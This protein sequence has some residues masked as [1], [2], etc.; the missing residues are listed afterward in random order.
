MDSSKYKISLLSLDSKFATTHDA[1]NGEFKILLPTTIKNVMRIR[2]A[3][4]EIPFIEYEFSGRH[5]NTTF[6]VKVG[7]ATTFTKCDP[8]PDGNYTAAQLVAAVEDS[9]QAVHASFTCTHD[10]VTGLVTIEN[11]AVTFSIYMASYDQ[12][13]AQRYS[14]WG[15]GY[16]LGFKKQ[17]L[18]ST[19]VSGTTY[20]LTGTRAAIIS[21]TKYYL[22][23]LECPDAVENVV[24]VVKDKGYIGAFAK[25]LL[26]DNAF[27]FNFDDNSNLMRKEFT[28]LAP[29][30]VPFFTCR[31][32]DA[33]GEVVDMQGMDWSL[34]V[35]VTEVTNSRTYSDI[36]RTYAR[37]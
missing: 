11:S 6:A 18:T 22:L 3:S 34:T 2:M 28:F 9:L 19:L 1:S 17:I 26:K 5:G 33:W 14:D 20:R 30:S 10:P 32:L 16:N 23:Q 8:I 35:E 13:I 36:S 31:L 12:E 24:H 15:I 4:A 21:S 37:R 29:V 7:A 27:N 25:V